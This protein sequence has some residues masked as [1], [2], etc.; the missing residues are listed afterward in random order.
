MNTHLASRRQKELIQLGCIREVLSK[1]LD[2]SRR[3]FIGNDVCKL[4][5]AGALMT[6]SQGMWKWRAIHVCGV[7]GNLDLFHDR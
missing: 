1:N 5:L 4:R 7:E 6:H 2:E 3:H